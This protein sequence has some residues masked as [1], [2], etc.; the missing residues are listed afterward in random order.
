MYS[1]EFSVYFGIFLFPP[2]FFFFF[3]LKKLWF[4]EMKTSPSWPGRVIGVSHLQS[5]WAST[6]E[7]FG[8]LGGDTEN[9][10]LAGATLMLS[11]AVGF[12]QIP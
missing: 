4:V 9:W 8:H 3:F 1:M 6:A 10:G 5:P 12:M 7:E 11:S 2:L